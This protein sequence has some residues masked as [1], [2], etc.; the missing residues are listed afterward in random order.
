[1]S[2][3]PP[4]ADAHEDL[5]RRGSDRNVRCRLLAGAI[6]QRE[7]LGLKTYRS[8]IVGTDIVAG[9]GGGAAKVN[10]PE[11][12]ALSVKGPRCSMRPLL[13]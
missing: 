2:D 9:A 6:G 8:T 5:E 7:A 10:I 11:Q 4:M 1:M 12:L 13:I 3:D